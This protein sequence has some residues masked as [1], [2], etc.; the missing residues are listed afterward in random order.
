MNSFEMK[1]IPL[2]VTISFGLSKTLNKNFVQLITSFE[3]VILVEKI[4]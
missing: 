4:K 3:L 1:T 2:S